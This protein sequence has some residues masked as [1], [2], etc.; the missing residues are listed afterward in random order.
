MTGKRIVLVFAVLL[1]FAASLYET[2]QSGDQVYFDASVT[3]LFFLLIGRVLDHAMREK[4]RSA[5]T[6]LQ[7]LAPRGAM[8]IRSDGTREFWT[9]DDIEPGMQIQ[10]AAGDRIP[11]DG[12]IVHGES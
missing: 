6:G 4:A 5:V 8:V 9:L 12:R 7:R 2:A 11:V 3:L 10:L 1:A